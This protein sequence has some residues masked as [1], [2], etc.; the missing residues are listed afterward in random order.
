[1]DYRSDLWSLGV[2]SYECLTG[3]RPFDS[4]ALGDLLLRICTDPLP[5]VTA[6]AAV[7]P[8]VDAW[9]ARAL[10]R[11]P[12]ERFRSAVEMSDGLS[13]LAG[14]PT[15]SGG[16]SEASFASLPPSASLAPSARLSA[17]TPAAPPRRSSA[18]LLLGIA[19]LGI[20]ILGVVVAG[21]VGL[22]WYSQLEPTAATADPPAPSVATPVATE[23]PTAAPPP[24]VTAKAPVAVKAPSKSTPTATPPATAAAKPTAT[25]AATDSAPCV[26]ACQKIRACGESC[27]S[28]GP[29]IGIKRTIAIC[30]NGK[31]GCFA[32]LD[33]LK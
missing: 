11:D 16:A 12:A 9:L 21:V 2:I 10:A 31:S 17:S 19:A 20:G 25:T 22:V 5:A 3:R 27:D 14:V 7:P 32:L 6:L 8:E 24:P 13:T 23:T 26:A 1:V 4:D 29:C 33:C 28:S 15:L 18:G 30:V